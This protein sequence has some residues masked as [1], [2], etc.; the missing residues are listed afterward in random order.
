MINHF[1]VDVNLKAMVKVYDATL[2]K[3]L[4]VVFLLCYLFLK[5]KLIFGGSFYFL[6]GVV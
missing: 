4:S 3:N 6:P 1:S 5:Q 2:E